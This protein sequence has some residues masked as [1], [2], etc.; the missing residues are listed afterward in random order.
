MTKLIDSFI[1]KIL[2]QVKSQKTSLIRLEGIDDIEIYYHICKYFSNLSE[3]DNCIIKITKEKFDEFCSKSSNHIALNF[4]LQGKNT[5]LDDPV[6]ESYRINSYVDY[7]NAITKYRNQAPENEDDKTVL[8]LL[9]GT[10]EAQ[11]EGSLSETSYLITPQEI[12]DDLRVNYSNWFESLLEA[13]N[14]KTDDVLKSINTIYK[15]L[16]SDFNTDIVKLSTFIEDSGNLSFS[17]GQEFINHIFETLKDYWNIM[18]IKDIKY[19][20]KVS[21]LKT[22]KASA[23]R[24]L[25]D[26]IKF[27]MSS[28]D[29]PSKSAIEKIIKKMSKFVDANSINKDDPF[30]E[31]ESV[32]PNFHQF[33]NAVID[34]LNG[35][36][37]TENREQLKKLD[38]SI[39]HQIMG[40]KLP[41]I[42]SDKPKTITGEPIEAYS[43]MFFD[44]S[45]Q[46]NEMYKTLPKKIQIRVNRI[47]LSNCLKEDPSNAFS[48]IC[49]F[50]GG[51]L[52]FFNNSD[53]EVDGELLHFSYLNDEITDCFEYQNYAKMLHLIK[54]TGKWGEPSKIQFTIKACNETEFHNYDYTWTF[55]PY[56]AW[57]NAFSYLTDI[58]LKESNNS[59]FEIPTMVVCHNIQSF[60]SC[61]SEEEFYSNLDQIDE[62]MIYDTYRKDIRNYFKNTRLYSK[63]QLLCSEFNKF[64]IQMANCG[65]FA[66]LGELEKCVS[67][68]S[69]F[70]D[71]IRENYD[72]YSGVQKERIPLLA[73][74]FLITSNRSIV[75]NHDISQAILPAYHPVMLEKI[76]AK[77]QFIRSGFAELLSKYFVGNIS[78][79]N[80]S[81]MFEQLIQLSSI[82]QGADALYQKNNDYIPCKQMWE[83][84]GVYYGNESLDNIISSNSFG[85]SV[86][87]DDDDS[88]AFLKFTPESS[89][90]VRNI[91]DYIHTFPACVDGLRIAFI[92]PSDMQHIVSA[93]HHISKEL[94][95]TYTNA[96]INIELIC[97]NSKK[98]STA[99]LKRWLDNFFVGERTITIN[100]FLKYLT[101]NRVS[102]IEQLKNYITGF[103]ICFTYNILEPSHIQFDK[104]KK[105][106][107]DK[108]QPKF[109]MTL[110]P[111][112]TAISHGQSRRINVSQFQFLASKAHTQAIHKIGN[113]ANMAG[114]YRVFNTL[115][116]NNIQKDVVRTAHECCKW[117]VCID[118]A[119]DKKM[120][121]S[122]RS[123]A[124]IIGFTTGEGNYGELNVTVSARKDIL[125]DI[126]KL[127][128]KRLHEKFPNWDNERL[129]LA[130]KHCVDDLS[131]TM[132]GSRILKAL[133]PYDFE[134]H[135]FLAYVLTL[136]FLGFSQDNNDQIIRSL[137]SLD[138][139]KHWF[140]G[141]DN[142]RPDFMLLEIPKTADNLNPNKDLSINIKIIECKMGLANEQHID[143][144]TKQLKKGLS[145][146]CDHWSPKSSEVMHRYW[147]NQLYRAI[148]FSPINLPYNSDEYSI[149]RE[150][151][152]TI[153][154]GKIDISWS[155]D[156]FAF[157]LDYN[158]ESLD[159]TD[160]SFEF[161]ND[162]SCH[163]DRINSVIVHEFGQMYIQKMLLP[164]EKRDDLFEYNPIEEIESEEMN[165]ESEYES[166]SIRVDVLPTGSSIPSAK[167]VYV[168]FLLFLQNFT[169]HT[170]Q[171]CLDWFLRCF[172]ISE[173]DKKI[174]YESN[175]HYKWETVL[176]SVISLFRKHGLI[177]NSQIGVF[178]IT[179]LG[180]KIAQRQDLESVDFVNL[181]E[182][183]GKNEDTISPQK[184]DSETQSHQ[185][186]TER[187]EE[188]EIQDE[189]QSQSD[190]ATSQINRHND[191]SSIRFLLGEDLRTK[192][193]FYWEFGNKELN[194]RHLLIN[195]NSGCGKTYCIQSLLMEASLNHVSSVVFDYTGGFAPSK[196]EPIFKKALNDRIEQRFVRKDKIPVNPFKKQLIRM[197]EDFSYPEE[198]ADVA[199]KIADIFKSV[200]KS[201]G[202]QQFAC[203]YDAIL[204]GLRKKGE[205][206]DFDTMV[207]EL[208]ALGNSRANTV[209]SKLRPFTDLNC[210]V[211]DDTFSWESIRSAD[212]KVYIFQLAGYDRDTQILLTEFLLWD[213]WNFCAQD[214]DEKRPIILVMDEAQNLSH[215]ENTPSAKILTEGRKFG[216]SGWYATQFMKPQLDDA[217]IQRLQQAGQKLYFCPPDEGVMT[218]AK[219]IDITAQ[220]SKDWAER[221]KKLKKGECV[222]CGNMVRNGR[223]TK[224]EPKIIKISSLQ[225]RLSDDNTFTN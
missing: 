202:D 37:L 92:A 127:L 13:N 151:I 215:Q 25:K 155:G 64:A 110:I 131:E 108:D 65:F 18:S 43:K 137:I 68:Y 129:G 205:S 139:Y 192:E 177:E 190:I 162:S 16:F 49:N 15:A 45:V 5:V 63:F 71:E 173:E 122:D 180:Q 197:D 157:W 84:Y 104:S 210:F 124:K 112:T 212:G 123:N 201:F 225:E 125:V 67:T 31:N 77:E 57:N 120:L 134:I 118:P 182:S 194:N 220:G 3:L 209:L 195:G 169:D 183:L 211:K 187:Q 144:A 179:E 107:I 116:M 88:K 83:Y 199:R 73:N 39:I 8:I 147:L 140:T 4:F 101:V 34:Y 207:S 126:K 153:I 159:E 79:K 51:I 22:E 206:M 149:I 69:A 103:D 163:A 47:V 156:V 204:N 61:E 171:S 9:L 72:S 132:D 214:G 89:V 102:D 80:L 98:N 94:E 161:K 172:K 85:M 176:D 81:S 14:I 146:M 66:S 196:L 95:K 105:S 30:P 99:Y 135:S 17:T 219:N 143:K 189:P 35:K 26:D 70:M 91:M 121:E 11:D 222:T 50:L 170:R 186:E 128:Q 141:E 97:M 164:N 32:F 21:N 24:I 150:K 148:I 2:L 165:E 59:I 117:V 167:K 78:S 7:D 44:S 119:I 54:T 213:I 55:S 224:Y 223:W 109:P 42:S 29:I 138:S 93:M 133:N 208:D 158:S 20:P 221:L 185:E 40:S 200:Y 96:T 36:N 203:M 114:L 100:T 217:E 41:R 178:H 56:S 19:I 181:I 86:V 191:L 174:V 198:D 136:Q 33:Q 6:T 154:D 58:V 160:I 53:I 82:T 27:I 115:S 193:K 28:E 113:P 216:I 12:I 184:G 52:S 90:L 48:H 152:Y 1:R 188:L 60:L 218:V 142:M 10:E 38:Y 87:T 111:D 145:I 74:C 75:E 46:F 62:E 168:P 166:D 106:E 175:N 23:I 76:E 130:A